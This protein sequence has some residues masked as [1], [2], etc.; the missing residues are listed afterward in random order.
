[1]IRN[2]IQIEGLHQIVPEPTKIYA[3]KFPLVYKTSRTHL[4]ARISF[5]NNNKRQSAQ[6][7][8]HGDNTAQVLGQKHR[9]QRWQPEAQKKHGRSSDRRRLTR[10]QNPDD[11]R[12]H[13]ILDPTIILRNPRASV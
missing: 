7:E 12:H 4:N 9:R 3:P 6:L 11:E 8:N 2:V 1:M 13:G 5:C 10:N